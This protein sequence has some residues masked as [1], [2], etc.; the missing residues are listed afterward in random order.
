MRAE[1]HCTVLLLYPYAAEEARLCM[2]SQLLAGTLLKG[3][4]VLCK[5]TELVSWETKVIDAAS[6]PLMHT[7]GLGNS[8]CCVGVE[9]SF[10]TCSAC[11][12]RITLLR[13]KPYMF[14]PDEEGE[15][16]MRV[17][18]PLAS[19]LGKFRQARMLSQL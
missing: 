17:K 7:M 4:P 10:L 13:L 3:I 16:G 6:F 9:A 14:E 12:C 15:T 2:V 8:R 5:Q 19:F 18:Q 11:V 1:S